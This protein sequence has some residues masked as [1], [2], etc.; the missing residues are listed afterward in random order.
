ML[1]NALHSDCCCIFPAAVWLV[2]VARQVVQPVLAEVAQ[3][4]YSTT[5]LYTYVIP[6][7]YR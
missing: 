4:V 3:Y 1:L 2:E 6:M 5:V 7:L